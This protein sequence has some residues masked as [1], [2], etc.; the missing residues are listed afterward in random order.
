MI[1]HKIL[2]ILLIIFSIGFINAAVVEEI[3]GQEIPNKLKPLIGNQEINIYLDNVFS[4]SLNILE[5]KIDYSTEELNKTSLE[6]Y[7]SNEV[8]DKILNSEN[9]STKVVEYYNS[10]EIVIKRK[11]I[12]NKIKFFFLNLFI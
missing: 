7:L 12:M 9:P 4:F 6:V 1:E 11:T 3:Q 2:C 5:G 8:L 10:G